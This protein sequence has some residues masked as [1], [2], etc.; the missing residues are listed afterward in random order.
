RCAPHAARP[1]LLAHLDPRP[2]FPAS[3]AVCRCSPSHRSGCGA[4]D[5]LPPPPP[6]KGGEVEG[7]K[8][9]RVGGPLRESKRP[10]E[11][12]SVAD[13]FSKRAPSG[14]APPPP[15]SPPAPRGGGCCYF[16]SWDRPKPPLMD[17]L[18]RP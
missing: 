7:A 13:I 14:E 6:A 1:S 17:S 2:G 18:A 11:S 10:W 9:R 12:S 15:P 4:Y 16:F 3:R 8:R 5:G